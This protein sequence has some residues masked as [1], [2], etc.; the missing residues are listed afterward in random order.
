MQ[1]KAFTCVYIDCLRTKLYD[2]LL[3]ILKDNLFI[4]L[5][6]N[7]IIFILSFDNIKNIITFSIFRIKINKVIF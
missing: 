5:K 3:L 6:N 4:L 2:L 7:T 1:I